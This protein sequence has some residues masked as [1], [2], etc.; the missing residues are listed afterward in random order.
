MRESVRTVTE[1]SLVAD[2]ASGVSEGGE[3]R[4]FH[5]EGFLATHLTPW[6]QEGR[7]GRIQPSNSSPR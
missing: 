7:I 5:I 3:A 4:Q 1:P 2:P 6:A